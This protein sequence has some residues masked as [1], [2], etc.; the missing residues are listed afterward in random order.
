M[1]TMPE[2]T[3]HRDGSCRTGF[4]HSGNAPGLDP[5]LDPSCSPNPPN[6]AIVLAGTR[7]VSPKVFPACS[8]RRSH[9]SPGETCSTLHRGSRSPAN[10]EW[11]G[12]AG[13]VLLLTPPKPPDIGHWALDVPTHAHRRSYKRGGVHGRT[14]DILAAHPGRVDHDHAA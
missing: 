12:R 13:C 3:M 5:G 11:T 4:L 1:V 2:R 10:A 7:G 8:A 14:G 6:V 9:L